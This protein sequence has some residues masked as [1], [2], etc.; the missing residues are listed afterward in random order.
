MTASTWFR[1]GA[2][3]G[4]L[5]VSAGAFGAHWLEGRL[6]DPAFVGSSEGRVSPDRRLAVFHTGVTYHM[7]HALA[8]VA[9]GLLLA[10]A[11]ESVG[12]AA[13]VAGWSFLLGV[14]LFSGSLYA[15]ALTG[16][17][18]LGAITPIGGVG[19]LVGWACLV[20]AAWPSK[21]AMP[22]L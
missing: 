17:R 22:D 11:P 2:I 14:A 7:S 12:I 20:L 15:M 18:W 21:A 13:T 6:K 8:L 4:F 19:F 3:L 10:R 1:I 16:H 5:A 9:L